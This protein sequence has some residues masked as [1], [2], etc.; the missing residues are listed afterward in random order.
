MRWL[1][2][3]YRLFHPSGGW[4]A[5]AVLCLT[6]ASLLLTLIMGAARTLLSGDH[7][8][9]DPAS[10]VL[11]SVSPKTHA[12]SF[13]V[14][15]EVYQLWADNSNYSFEEMAAEVSQT[16]VLTARLRSQASEEPIHV[17]LVTPNYF[18]TLG[19]RA[20]W[21]RTFSLPA[22]SN[23]A[24]EALISESV[25]QS[26]FAREKEILGK[27]IT[28]NQRIYSIAGVVPDSYPA[29]TQVW[30]DCPLEVSRVLNTKL[31]ISSYYTVWGRLK[32]GATRYQAEAELDALPHEAS[33]LREP[34]K[35]AISSLT[36][37]L[38]RRNA[39]TVR[40]IVLAGIAI[41]L[42]SCGNAGVILLLRALARERNT[43]LRYVLGA[44][45]GRMIRRAMAESLGLALIVSL[46]VLGLLPLTTTA[47]LKLMPL[48]IAE[49]GL[50]VDFQLIAIA[51]LTS[52][53]CV[54]CPA[55]LTL[56]IVL[57]QS[58]ANLFHDDPHFVTA[59]ERATHVRGMLLGCQL[60][61]AAAL[62]IIALLLLKSAMFIT[63]GGLAL[64]PHNCVIIRET[65]MGTRLADSEGQ[66]RYLGNVFTG[67]QKINAVHS[68]GASTFLPLNDGR[69]NVLLEVL[70]STEAQTSSTLAAEQMSVSGNYFSAAG[71]D[72]LRGRIFDSSDSS[73]SEPVMIVDE[74][75]AQ[76]IAP[77]TG[78]L[79]RVVNV[80][81]AKRKIVGIC[82]AAHFRGFGSG[83]MPLI[84]VPLAQTHL[85]LPFAAVVA[86]LDYLSPGILHEIQSETEAVD[87]AAMINSVEF[88]E[89]ILAE[90]LRVQTVAL[91]AAAILATLGFILSLVG[92]SAVAAYSIQSRQ[93]EIG[94]RLALGATPAGITKTILRRSLIYAAA[95]LIFGLLLAYLGSRQLSSLIYGVRPFNTLI[96]VAVSGVFIVAI[97]FAAFVEGRKLVIHDVT[98]LLRAK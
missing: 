56:G 68:I 43:A 3:L 83:N 46:A 85:A 19:I 75:L 41:F 88:A 71:T 33:G 92:I 84:Y 96:Y 54:V 17:A 1:R 22:Q 87:R 21:G 13:P 74:T 37:A 73:T 45:R 62:T 32:K 39:I 51:L 14:S 31:L 79:E 27:P 24:T 69:Y 89:D 53:I 90:A 28:I 25:W 8:L 23:G 60:S 12:A 35:P 20:I 61:V 95:G 98:D 36:T 4:V 10:L 9:S 26:A 52:T 97:T 64:N 72:L 16:F 2:D 42:I 11:I 93:H 50:A 91:Y 44:T 76:Q 77:G 7:R 80:E 55:L 5:V 63:N 57:R 70:P 47:F 94:V 67:L 15:P 58:H 81:G 48:E 6:L 38:M 30:L 65:L 66:L 59:G 49:R 82:R 29:G 18:A 86:R 78:A 40:M 34:W